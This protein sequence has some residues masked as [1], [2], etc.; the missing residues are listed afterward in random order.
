MR[1]LLAALIVF[2][3]CKDNDQ[4]PVKVAP[5]PALTGSA[6]PWNAPAKPTGDGLPTLG[7][8]VELANKACPAVT[9]PFF[10]ELTKAGKTSH[11]LG[12]RHISVGLAKFP[13]IVGA[14]LDQASLA[15]F[16]IAPDDTTDGTHASEPLEQEL[17]PKDWAHYEELV[18]KETAA[19]LE[20]GQADSAALMMLVLYEDISNTLET[21]LQQRAGQ[22]H[23]KMSGLETSEF[24]DG[25]LAKLLD[26]RML[27][28]TIEQTKDRA[29]IKKDSLDDLA[30]YCAGTDDSPGMDDESRG[31]M[32]KAGY[33]KAEL[34]ADDEILVFKRNADWIPKLSKLFEHDKVFVAVGA[35]HLIGP[36]G[37]I[38]L[39]KAQGFAVTRIKP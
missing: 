15:V 3:G 2:V 18:G 14:T 24:Q 27:K 31:K 30:E 22:H 20:T 5:K 39:M 25:V 26:L 12:T 10:F 38:E 34:D 32:M 37:V 11:I 36:R 8:R 35:D 21:Q 7:E 9:G 23:I 4:P 6:D 28:A 33:T 29:E 16:E 19:R 1:T 17:G 13:P